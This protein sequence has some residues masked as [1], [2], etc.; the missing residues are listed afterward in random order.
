MGFWDI[1]KKWKKEE[2]PHHSP[3]KEPLSHMLLKRTEGEL[4][5]YFNWKDTKCHKDLLSYISQ[6][7]KV[8]K[9][10]PCEQCDGIDFI[11][12]SSFRGFIVHFM[13]LD[14]DCSEVRHL[15]DYLKERIKMLGYRSYV[16][17]VKEFQKTRW[18]EKV[19]RH[20][21]KPK[22]KFD[23]DGKQQQHFGNIN[24][25]LLFR[26]E[27]PLH[28]KFSVCTYNDR[29]FT[30]ARTFDDLLQLITS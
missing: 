7:Y 20:Y 17:D 25:E 3:C 30:E 14:R 6:N 13:D 11:K 9:E 26:D 12:M 1:F 29:Q 4:E 23:D 24:I 8:W 18:I 19:E 10:T 15:F 27:E 22:L 28:L 2:L 16:S 5:S 21:L